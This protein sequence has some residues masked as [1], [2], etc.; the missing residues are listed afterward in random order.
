M[1]HKWNVAEAGTAASAASSEKTIR[2]MKRMNPPH[3]LTL[4]NGRLFLLFYA[5]RI[6]VIDLVLAPLQPG[7]ADERVAIEGGLVQHAFGLQQVR[8]YPHLVQGPYAPVESLG[9]HFRSQVP[10]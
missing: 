7:V 6:A 10:L 5:R 2:R 8:P 4:R 1:A 9:V 3:A